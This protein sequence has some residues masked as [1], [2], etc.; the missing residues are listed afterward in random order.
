[1]LDLLQRIK[2]SNI[3]F[4][5]DLSFI[6]DWK[7]FASGLSLA[8]ISSYRDADLR[9]QI[10]LLNTTNLQLPAPMQVRCQLSEQAPKCGLVTGNFFTH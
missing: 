3:S 10:L 5:G 8:I 4:V 1:M 6:N 9:M 7:Y 2:D